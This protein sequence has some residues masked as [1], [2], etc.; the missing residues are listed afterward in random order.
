M[1]SNRGVAY[2]N[3]D[4]DSGAAKKFVIDPPGVIAA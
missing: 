1:A 3:M 4:F 2:L